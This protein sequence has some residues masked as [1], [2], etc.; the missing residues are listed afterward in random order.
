M[1]PDK[2]AF[3]DVETTG[4]SVTRDR[5][6]E[7]GILKVEK[8][9]VTDTFSSLVNPQTYV[10]SYI[11]NI[12]H[13][14]LLDLE[15]APTF[16]EIQN[17]I[18]EMLEGSILVAHNARFD[19]GFLRNEFRR[20]G[21]SFSIKHFCTARLSRHLFPKHR[22][23]NLDSIIQR[24]SIECENRHRA[25]D[26]AKV[27]WDYLQIIQKTLPEKEFTKA[28]ENAMHIPSIPSFLPAKLL[29]TLPENP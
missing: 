11:E 9:I 16:Y 26:D 8:G 22:H 17:R 12:T 24:Y 29:D 19:Y 13:I 4:L 2:L 18:L 6:I 27:L 21:K 7:I 28:I 10:S 1:L 14:Q 25:F 15:K 5:I 20:Y 23:H 3:L